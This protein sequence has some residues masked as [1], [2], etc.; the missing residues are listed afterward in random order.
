MASW[1]NT[2]HQACG[3]DG[4]G[5]AQT[6]QFCIVPT[7]LLRNA[8]HRGAARTQSLMH[9]DVHLVPM[10]TAHTSAN[11][12][13]HIYLYIQ[14]YTQ[15]AMRLEVFVRVFGWRRLRVYAALLDLFIHIKLLFSVKTANIA[16][17][18]AEDT[19]GVN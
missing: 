11:L 13:I 14:T 17:M 19:R 8:K 18:C 15:F 10:C 9:G 2:Q 6:E 7:T 4:S 5:I 12:Y 3:V 1:R 16:V